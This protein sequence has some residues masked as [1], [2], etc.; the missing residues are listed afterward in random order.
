MSRTS[1][2]LVPYLGGNASLPWRNAGTPFPARRRETG[3]VAKKNVFLYKVL[4]I[5][6]RL[7][8]S[9]GKAQ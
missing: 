5:D 6:D 9:S 8:Y 4:Q 2:T 7:F 3:M 1:F